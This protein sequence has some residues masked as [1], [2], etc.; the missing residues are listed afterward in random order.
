MTVM[1]HE[2]LSYGDG[3]VLLESFLALDTPEGFQAELIDREIVVTPPPGSRHD[4]TI[5]K[6]VGQVYQRS[7]TQ[8]DYLPNKGL[9]VPA[10]DPGR[11]ERMIPDATFAPAELDIFDND[12]SWIEPAGIALVVEV[13]SS[14]PARD[15]V[16]KRHGYA[17]AS[18]PLYLLVDR[19]EKKV[20]LFGGPNDDDYRS[21]S[22]V[23]FGQA[24]TL[25]K[26]FDIELDTSE[27]A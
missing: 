10:A 12:E 9:K 7:S 24:I 1:V 21:V 2:P 27:F 16:A 5:G 6:I 8:F 23:P 26:P 4:R 14:H 22:W 13:T 3:D 20:T 17:R 19:E 18:I 11:S 25:P 15:R